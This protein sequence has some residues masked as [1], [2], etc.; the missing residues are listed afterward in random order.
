M[1]DSESLVPTKLLHLHVGSLLIL[2][3]LKNVTGDARVA[4]DLSNCIVLTFLGP[5]VKK[6]LHGISTDA[7]LPLLLL[8]SHTNI[9]HP[10]QKYKCI[11]PSLVIHS[12]VKK[13]GRRS[14]NIGI[15]GVLGALARNLDA[16]V[17]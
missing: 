7:F 5:R 10:L 12:T 6:T 1:I 8:S 3:P 14:G 9:K 15:M 4:S 17:G 2:Q 11:C 13:T 16:L